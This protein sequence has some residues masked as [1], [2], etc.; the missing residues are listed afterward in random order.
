MIVDWIVLR[1]RV[2]LAIFGLILLVLG[3]GLKDLQLDPN[4]RV[5]FSKDHQHYSNLLELETRFGSNTDLMFLIVADE[6]IYASDQLALATNW[7]TSR[8][9]EIEGVVAV[10][11]LASFPYAHSNSD[12]LIVSDV[13]DYLCPSEQSC[14]RVREEA[15]RSRYL[16]NRFLES[17]LNIMMEDPKMISLQN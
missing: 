12:D 8:A 7:L 11:S 16:E 2:V 1:P 15:I 3:V 6:D 10:D 5:F 4:N 13:L 14:L 9:W 17:V